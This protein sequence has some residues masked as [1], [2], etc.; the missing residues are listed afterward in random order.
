M[1]RPGARRRPGLKGAVLQ[2]LLILAALYLPGHFLGP[3]LAHKDDGLAELLLLRLSASLA[4][5]AP[6]LTLLATAG[7][8][9]APA[10]IGGLALLAVGTFLLGR[11]PGGAGRF[12]AWDLGAL[13]LVAGGFGLYC[14]PAE[15]VLNSRDP[16]VYFL[17]ADK[18]ARTGALLHRDP[19]VGAVAS[20][21][22]FLEGRK[23][24]GFYVY[25]Q[26]LIVPQFFPGPF[27]FLG[28]GDLVGGTWGNLLV[29]P[30]MGALA[31]GVAYALGSELFG[32]WAGLLGAALL[33]MSYTQVWWA[34]HPSS[35]V[36]TAL[37]VLAGLWFAVRFVRGA[38][39]LTGVFAG[40]LLGGVMLIRVDAFLA[41][42]AIPVLFGLDLLARRPLGR[43]LYP[44]VP[45]VVF[46]GL[47]LLYL[48]TLGS[49]YLYVIYTEH[50]LKEAIALAPYAVP[51]FLVAVIA[52]LYV[53]RRWG[54]E[55]GSYLE[56]RSGWIP[57]VGA[58]GLAVVALWAYFVVPVPWDTLPDGSRDFDAY[59]SQILIR[60][61]LFVTPPV[62]VLG[63]VGFVLAARRMD[64]GRA[65]LFG[66]FLAF[67]ALYAVIPN[68]AP[69]LPWATR[70]FVPVAFP[71][72]ALLAAHAT[73]EIGH[74][75][76]RLL[77]RR[78]GVVVSTAVAALALSWT[79]Y[80]TLPILTFQELD[81]AVAAFDRVEE[82]IPS[83][84]VVYMEMP[85]GYD[86]TA[87]TFEY[88]YDRPI[89]PY[90]RTRFV[91]EV[92]ELDGAELLDDAVYVTT[93]GGPAPLLA[94]WNFREVATAKLDLPRLAAVEKEL[95][96]VKE[97][98]RLDYR[99][100]RVE[101][102]R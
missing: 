83:A 68:V 95:P 13:A 43:W 90:D 29:V 74:G 70:R 94:D 55:I 58:G 64:A 52:F 39:P 44:G 53:R 28:L 97:S 61:V 63:L 86:I 66:A 100:F 99:V 40:L 10:I 34:R 22:P 25:G 42:A 45:L 49:R 82:K 84:Q 57:L 2:G 19:L 60:L 67:G 33:G 1:G 71:I 96:T 101:R 26:D 75:L 98:L 37:L 93:D 7:W 6:L 77:N 85:E 91:R 21:H 38:G 56:A 14:R 51:F 24:P 88:L 23:Y 73:V 46:A 41:A 8:F 5:A 92:D 17:F 36:M 65:L 78:A 9:T 47:T 12:I 16:G 11:G 27:A 48:N 79:F 30:V 20:F 87:S 54:A 102:E 35:E 69:D 31:V 15:Y 81:G 89:L 50:G 80:A 62:A 4:L 72:L 18:L 3:R 32:R 76:S 59:R